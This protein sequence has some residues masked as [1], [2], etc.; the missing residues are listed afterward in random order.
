MFAVAPAV[1]EVTV[2]LL[3]TKSENSI[4]RAQRSVKDLYLVVQQGVVDIEKAGGT[5]IKQVIIS[6]PAGKKAAKNNPFQAI[7]DEGLK[8]KELNNQ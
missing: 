3:T 2:P 1:T 6:Q 4:N 5:P 8:P 7:L